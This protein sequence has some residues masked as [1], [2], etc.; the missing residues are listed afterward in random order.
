MICSFF[1]EEWELEDMPSLLRPTG[2][3]RNSG[4]SSWALLVTDTGC[5]HYMSGNAPVTAGVVADGRKFLVLLLGSLLILWA[6]MLAHHMTFIRRA[7][8]F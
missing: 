1:P 6:Q 3:L 5:C 7:V 4:G 2:L 8:S